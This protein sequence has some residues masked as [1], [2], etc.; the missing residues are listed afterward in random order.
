MKNTGEKENSNEFGL[1]RSHCVDVSRSLTYSTN[2]NLREVMPP[3][4]CIKYEALLRKYEDRC[5]EY[6]EKEG[7]EEAGRKTNSTLNKS[8]NGTNVLCE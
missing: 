7:I 6:G 5:K 3:F 8:C 4:E 2:F 1:N